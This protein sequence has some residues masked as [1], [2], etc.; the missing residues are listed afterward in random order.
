MGFSGWIAFAYGWLA[1]RLYDELAWIYD[2]VSWFVSAGHWDE[3][4][5]F[6][7]D[8]IR[9]RRVLELGFG[10]GE[11]LIELARRGYEVVGLEPSSAMQHQT[12]AKLSRRDFN[13]P[14]VRAFAQWTPFANESFDTL[15]ATFP[16][17][18]ILEPATWR[19]ARRVLRSP[20]ASS[21]TAGGRFVVA[22]IGVTSKRRLSSPLAWLSSGKALDE[23]L[24]RCEGIA[25]ASGFDIRV[26]VHERA[27]FEV[28]VVVAERKE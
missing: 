27:G 14:R 16:A 25:H 8:H 19:E 18:Y 21:G 17:N 2:P 11:L 20:E 1:E 6:T 13:I 4:R 10:T 26:V 23:V 9:G 12:S 28:P 15:I 22:G 24:T 7:L 5:K 3:W